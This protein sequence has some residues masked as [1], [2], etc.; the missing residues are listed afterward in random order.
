V[1]WRLVA[2]AAAVIAA[3]V[4]ARAYGFGERIV[5]L[6]AWIRGLGALGYVAF[7]AIYTIAVVAAVPGSAITVLAGALFGSVGGVV[8]VS[9]SSTLGACLAFLVARYVARDAVSAWLGASGRFQ[10]LDALSAESGALMVAFTRLV[11]LFPFNLLNYA[12]GLT[13]VRFAT[14]A[15]WSWLCMLPA[16]I[17]VVVGTDAASGAVA[18]GRVPWHLAGVAAGALVV[19]L[20]LGW[21]L[22][23]RIRL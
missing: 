9:V 5:A 23:R 16:T 15:F 2:L 6:Q 12:F 21:W 18:S 4:A 8:V 10:R 20:A 3:L 19:L 11:P 17:L 22:K 14:Y 7:A 1:P 13:R